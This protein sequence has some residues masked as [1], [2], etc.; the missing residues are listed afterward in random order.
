MLA[1]LP[2][3]SAQA[4]WVWRLVF[5]AFSLI[6]VTLDT[7]IVILGAQRL[8]FGKPGASFLQ[9]WVPFCQLRDTLED[10][11]SSRGDM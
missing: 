6:A 4:S 1:H 8:S 11:G 2:C 5:K 7:D 3:S 10:H 9:P